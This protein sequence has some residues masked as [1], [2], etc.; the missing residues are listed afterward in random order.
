MPQELREQRRIA[1]EKEFELLQDTSARF[2]EH[3]LNDIGF[4]LHGPSTDSTETQLRIQGLH[5]ASDRPAQ[6]AQQVHQEILPPGRA[7]PFFPV[8]Q[9]TTLPRTLLVGSISRSSTT[10]SN[11]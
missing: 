9:Q 5:S 8:V 6:N 10:K 2:L 1:D 3:Q 11:N 4:L 7:Q